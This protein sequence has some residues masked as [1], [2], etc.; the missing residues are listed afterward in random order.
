MSTVVGEMLRTT[1]GTWT[2]L[3]PI[4]YSYQWRSNAADIEGATAATYTPVTADVGAMISC[5]VTAVNDEGVTSTVSN[6]LGPVLLTANTL[7]ANTAAPVIADTTPRVGETINCTLG[8]W[9]GIPTPTFSRQWKRGSSD[10]GTNSPNYTLV[11]AD[12]G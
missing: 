10:V 5:R 11:T 6:Q 7:P 4:T 9:T 2:G 8:T 12:L 3:K 1:N